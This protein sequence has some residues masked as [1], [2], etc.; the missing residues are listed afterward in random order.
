MENQDE[1]FQLSL[2]EASG[3]EVLVTMSIPG[4]LWPFL[5]MRATK[6]IPPAENDPNGDYALEY[7]Q[8]GDGNFVTRVTISGREIGDILFQ[9]IDTYDLNPFRSG[10][11]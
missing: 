1:N 3:N 4:D 9:G 11:E 5:R 7:D 10:L 2:E 8:Y 6:Y